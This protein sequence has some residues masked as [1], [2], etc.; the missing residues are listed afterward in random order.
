MTRGIAGGLLESRRVRDG[1]RP[2]SAAPEFRACAARGGARTPSA[3][4]TRSGGVRAPSRTLATA[5]SATGSPARRGSRRPSG[6]GGSARSDP[7]S[8]RRGAPWP[9]PDEW[10]T[11]WLQRPGSAANG[12]H[13]RPRG[14]RPRIGPPRSRARTRRSAAAPPGS[15]RG[16]ERLGRAR[17]RWLRGIARRHG[18]RACR[19]RRGPNVRGRP[20]ARSRGGRRITSTLTKH[21]VR[22]CER[23]R[24]EEEH[25]QDRD[26]QGAGRLRRARL[27]GPPR[28]HA[29][30]VHLLVAQLEGRRQLVAYFVPA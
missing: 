6:P 14:P 30:P 26:W 7:R 20:S 2:V 15:L 3:L 4:T 28:Q 25:R 19:T 12:P 27:G 16:R 17:R 18:S 5:A 29:Q 9:S 11:S 10:P 21:F 13:A 8:R 1:R 22:S 24:S 23:R